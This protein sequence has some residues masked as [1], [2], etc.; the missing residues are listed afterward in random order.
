VR[1]RQ[2]C[3][4]FFEGGNGESEQCSRRY[5]T[6]EGVICIPGMKPCFGSRARQA[7]TTSPEP[8][9]TFAAIHEEASVAQEYPVR[10][11]AEPNSVVDARRIGELA[12]R[13][14]VETARLVVGAQMR[15]GPLENLVVV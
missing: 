11:G 7:S 2:N 1:S 6:T 8:N 4:H 3:H 12:H 10:R 14:Y 13:N 15:F 9:H 5:R